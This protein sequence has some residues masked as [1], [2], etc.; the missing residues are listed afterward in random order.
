MRF[1]AD[2]ESLI[3]CKALEIKFDEFFYLN[4]RLPVTVSS[5]S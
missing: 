1:L 5:R 3:R 4:D 2:A